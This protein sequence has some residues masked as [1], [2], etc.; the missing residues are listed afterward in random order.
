LASSTSKPRD[1]DTNSLDFSAGLRGKYAARFR[2]MKLQ[3]LL[4]PDV[5]RAFPTSAAVNQTLRP[6]AKLINQHAP[7]SRRRKAS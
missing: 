3:V 2:K 5:A 7:K 4:D 1:R 6:I